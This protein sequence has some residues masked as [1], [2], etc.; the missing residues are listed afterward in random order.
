VENHFSTWM[1]K[2]SAGPEWREHLEFM[3]LGPAPFSELLFASAT[4]P[5]MLYYLDQGR[6][7]AGSINEN[8]AREVMELHTVGVGGGYD[9]EEVTSLARLLCGL[10]FSDEALLSGMGPFLMRQFQFAPDLGSGSEERVLGLRFES[11][12]GESAGERFDRVRLAL[13]HLAAHPATARFLATK[14]AEHYVSVPA[15][16][17]LIDSLALEYHESGGDLGQLVALIAGHPAFW[18]AMETPRITSPSDFALRIARASGS[19]QIAGAVN[20]YLG[21][22]GMGVFDRSTPD[23]YPEED[24]AWAD[25][26]GMLQ[27]WNLGREI[28]WAFQKLVPQQLN[29]QPA[30]NPERWCQRVVDTAAVRL[31]G[32]TLDDASNEAAIGF[33]REAQ[34]NSW[35]RVRDTVVLI[36]GL[37]EASLE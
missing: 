17:A 9:Q 10:T 35:E 1:Q 36:A 24:E 3:R 8:Y 6:S 29:N 14:L 32:R 16:E 15:P 11:C 2:A 26:N 21:R 13:E 31:T 33:L 34:G 7:W 27:R 25:T 23:G 12:P 22:S 37:P 5:A 28:P 18:E 30:G 20:N 19:P 4:S